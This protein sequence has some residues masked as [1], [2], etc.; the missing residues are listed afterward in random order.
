MLANVQ[1]LQNQL[2]ELWANVKFLKEYNRACLIAFME[3]KLKEQ[4]SYSDL[5]IDGFGE[6]YCLDRDPTVTDKPLGGGLCLC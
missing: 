2:D 1:S 6:P 4:G 3:T 5:D